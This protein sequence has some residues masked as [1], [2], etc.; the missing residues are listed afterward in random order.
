MLRKFLPTSV[1]TLSASLI[2][3]SLSFF[4]FPSLQIA[5]A[6]SFFD[7]PPVEG[8]IVTTAINAADA[9]HCFF[10]DALL[11]L[12]CVTSP[13]IGF[14]PGF[15]STGFPSTGSPTGT[16]TQNPSTSPA[17][18]VVR[19]V[20]TAIPPT[21]AQIIAGLQAV[22]VSGLP[23]F[24]AEQL[25][26]PKGDPGSSGGGSSGPEGPAG[27]QGPA[28]ASGTASSSSG[29]TLAVN[30]FGG[31]FSS[32]SSLSFT[33]SGFTVS[34]TGNLSVVGLDYTNGPASRSIAQTITGVWTFTT[35]PLFA[36]GSRLVSSNS[37]DFDEFSNALTV[38]A[39]TTINAVAGLI[40]TNAS[41]S[42]T[43]E[44]S[45]VKATTLTS[46][47]NL[48]Q[49]SGAASVS[50]NLEVA[51]NASSSA[52]FGSGLSSCTGSSSK[53]LWNS[54]TGKFS[55]GT[56]AGAS[57]QTI[58]VG[59]GLVFNSAGSISF[60]PG[61][62]NVSFV[63]P[64]ST[65]RLDWTNGPASRSIAQTITG[66][67]LFTAASNQFSNTLEIGTASVSSIAINGT[68]FN[69]NAYLLLTGG[70]L[71][72]NLFGTN[73]SFSG[74]LESAGNA[75]A[76]HIF[77]SGLSVCTTGQ[78]LQYNTNGTFTC[79]TDQN[80][81]FAGLQV[82]E[83][84]TLFSG[85]TSLSFDPGKFSIT[86]SGG[87]DVALNLD[88][89]AGGP[90]SRSAINAWTAHN[91][92]TG[93]VSV[94]SAFEVTGTASVSST[95]FA[96]GALIVSGQT[97]LTNA[98]VSANLEVSG[99]SSA[100]A[101]FGSGLTLC[102]S[103]NQFLQYNSVTGKF[104]C[105]TAT[106]AS[107]NTGL[108]VREDSSGTFAHITSLSFAAP[109]FDISFTGSQSF[110]RLDW[111]NGPA[112]R[113]IAQTIT[114]NWHFTNGV[115][116]SSAFEVTGT[117]SVSSTLFANGALAVVGQTT[118]TNA[119]G[120]NNLELTGVGSRLGINSGASTDTSLE[121]GGT[122]SVSALIVNGIAFSGR[123]VTSNSLDFDEFSNAMTV[124]SATT[125]NAAAGLTFTNA[126][127]STNFELT[128]TGSRL[129]INSGASTD[130]SFEVGGTASISSTLT[131]SGSLISLF[132]ASSSFAGSLDV[133]KGIRGLDITANG[134]LVVN[135]S[136]T[137]LSGASFS[138]NL[139]LTS[140]TG[141]LGINAG[142]STDA[143]F[144]VGGIASIS[145]TLLL[146][147]SG[148]RF[149][150]FASASSGVNVLT[151]NNLGNLVFKRNASL[152][153]PASGSFSIV[154]TASNQGPF[155]VK[156][157][158]SAVGTEVL[159][160]SFIGYNSAI[161]EEFSKH[162]PPTAS[163]VKGDNGTG[164]G[165]GGGWGVY[166]STGT[167]C[168]FSNPTTELNGLLRLDSQGNT[169]GCLSMIDTANNT[170]Y[171]MFAS[172]S[173]PTL[174]TKVRPSVADSGH[175][176]YVGMS[177]ATDGAL[178]AP[179]NFVGFSND[180]TSSTSW[181]GMIIKAGVKTA[182]AC[183]QTISTTK[184]ALLLVEVRGTTDTHF[185]IDSD[186]SDGVNLLECGTGTTAAEPNPRLAP[187]LIYQRRSGT[188]SGLL[189]VD[190]YRAWQDDNSTVTENGIAV[191]PNYASSSNIAFLYPTEDTTISGGDVVVLDLSSGLPR[192][193]LATI[194]YDPKAFGVVVRDPAY[195]VRNGTF[196]GVK[197]AEYGRASVKVSTANG[198]I[199]VGDYLAAST[200]PGV[201]VRATANPV[202][203]RALS[204]F[205]GPGIGRV[206][207]SLHA[208]VFP[209]VPII[210]NSASV[211]GN[212]EV[213][214]TA[215]V[216]STIFANGALTVL[217]KITGANASLSGGLELTSAGARLGLNA[218]GSTDTTLEVGGTASISG[219]L[220]AN[221][222]LTVTGLTTFNGGASF[223][224]NLELNAGRRLGINAGASTDAAF[225]VGGTASISG[226]LFANGALTVVG[227]TTFVGASGSGNFEL[228]GT[229]SRL[230]INSGAAT[231]A[232]LEVGGTASISGFTRFGASA[233]VSSNF[234]VSGYAS[235]SQVFGAGLRDCDNTDQKLLWTA[236]GSSQGKFSCGY[237][238][239]TNNIQVFS[240][241]AA[242]SWTRPASVSQVYVEVWGAGGGGGT[243]SANNA[244]DGGG[245]GGGYSSGLVT[246]TG[247][248]TVNVGT[249]GT[250]NGGTGGNSSF[251]GA[252]TP[253]GNGGV[254]T[255]VAAGGAGGTGTGGTV[256]LS[257]Q[258]GGDGFA[259]DGGKAGDGGGSPMGGAGGQGHGGGNAAGG[260]VAG[261][262]GQIPGGG[263]GGGEENGG[264]GGAG[265][266]GRV[267]VWATTGTSR[268]DIAEWYETDGTVSAG[269]VVTMGTDSLTY[270]GDD[271]THTIL[272]LTKAKS[273]DV[274]FGVVS[275]YPEI[276]MGKDLLAAAH[277]PMPIALAGRV[278]VS[279][280]SANGV[281]HAGDMLTASDIPGVAVRTDKAG[282][283]IGSALEDY[284]GPAGAA[285]KMLVF[286]QTGYSTGARLKSV[287]ASHGINLDEVPSDVDVGTVILAQ[288][289]QDK[290]NI[291]QATDI[292]EIFSD[293]IVAGLEIITP[294]VVTDAL[295]ANTIEP[296]DKDVTVQLPEGGSFTV[297]GNAFFHGALTA[298]SLTVAQLPQLTGVQT[299]LGAVSSQSLAL[300][301]FVVDTKA[302]LTEADVQL[303]RVIASQSSRVDT[304]SVRLDSAEVTLA[305]LATHSQALIFND[306]A[307]FGSDTYFFGTPY[308]TGDTGGFAIIS[309]G[310]T[311]VHINF[312]RSYI[313]TPVVNATIALTDASASTDLENRILSQNINFIVTRVSEDGFTIR[314]STAATT[315]IP[316]SWTALA[317]KEP[318]T[319]TFIAPFVSVI[320]E[321][322]ITTVVPES[323]ETAISS[324]SQT[325]VPSDTPAGNV[326]QT[327]LET[328]SETP[329]ESP[330]DS[331]T[332]SPDVGVSVPEATVPA[333]DSGQ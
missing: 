3:A 131:V 292:S 74:N 308:F 60:D 276:F 246:V 127:V 156:Y 235:V 90:A 187:Q 148:N 159:A 213:T 217:G 281:V 178:V 319:F 236:S 80:S 62:F 50:S 138:N 291:T 20:V 311:E 43:F 121:V 210:V 263:G 82:R 6:D 25:R 318:K 32:I 196:D 261:S 161:A 313:W 111:T 274:I 304:L 286:V 323:I 149:I 169:V 39:P 231:E 273:G 36:G 216:S 329:S 125:I 37:L 326:V 249:G 152:V 26:G 212:F 321:P 150:T 275:S 104:S 30:E 75:S 211:S 157:N 130:A 324:A 192:V 282:Q 72:G 66:P 132:T 113:S 38:D 228:T 287:M 147:S 306:T 84:A 293:R 153:V 19:P 238:N 327:P 17:I 41:T 332:P 34:N 184:F 118:F 28:G 205:T 283:I 143:A 146:T 206:V 224:S 252:T 181:F 325:S 9:V 320:P 260:A 35:N 214:G 93:G 79:V 99:N 168:N 103:A 330:A 265:A 316:L 170:P 166:E 239:R 294:R 94:S 290:Q 182:V 193:K 307:T 124:D 179:T 76:S 112:S 44:A 70:T 129:G 12:P 171:A 221:G 242:Q 91:A 240:A 100:S 98:S 194:S 279:V 122:A 86:A 163:Q 200:T 88:W 296:V 272:V 219:T 204:V 207:I 175:A 77:G 256:N 229:G 190:F 222:A 49:I 315:D 92:F 174:E 268:A 225:E 284:N 185:F 48:I 243:S 83:G 117:A 46:D 119:S 96:N 234:E 258:N 299:Q 300:E 253:T 270:T 267:V 71:T 133:V 85:I 312:D 227:Q 109:H 223:S 123:G 269:D 33:A 47:T 10:L 302:L 154:S 139:E 264:T 65:I 317:I 255:T 220:F 262:V 232:S 31:P 158:R 16:A 155:Q 11:G 297:N 201:A 51:G 64:V 27:P 259:A 45:V 59:E 247:N 7:L 137:F 301:Q 172:A 61:Q 162:Q 135:G 57:G 120:S 285:G 55:C 241:G 277:H 173:L 278:P 97:T 197:V 322:Q 245:G 254:G 42:G 151:I 230:G 63:S 309:A 198:N 56:D 69:P 191:T 126:S 1:S 140:P 21:Q 176:V 14:V 164:F 177:D 102:T 189:D 167:G 68:A 233:S 160:G 107:S 250:A 8:G 165:D 134:R 106:S 244:S 78:K 136:S 128:G 89:G 22:I 18:V 195:F 95:L 305:A 4:V 226:T 23:P 180:S 114:G 15:P 108:A 333:S 237:D 218:G 40:F 87:Q 2:L 303:V 183:S 314:L 203:G 53:L 141:R 328:P 188:A 52:T 215:S 5:S 209:D 58:S 54:V 288:M 257:G 199:A 110:V 289:I 116:V 145:N 186:V 266:D 142:T 310:Q 208:G 24:I 73:A 331:A 202:I 81:V 280:S 115:S 295:V 298:D 29:S 248:V 144:E 251:A 271:G 67:W 105:G 101:T 13:L